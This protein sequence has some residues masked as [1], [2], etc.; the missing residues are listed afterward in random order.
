MK[1]PRKTGTFEKILV[2]L[3]LAY[4]FVVSI[5]LLTEIGVVI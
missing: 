5:Y 2:A 3:L 1:I 4:L